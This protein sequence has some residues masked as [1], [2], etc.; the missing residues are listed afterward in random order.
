M[1]LFKNMLSAEESLFVNEIALDFDYLPKLLPHRDH[2]QFE[3]ATCIKP[4]FQK[5]SGKHILITGKP[6]IGK[7]AA[8]RF[9]LRD[10]HRETDKIMPIY[11]NCWKKD[12]AHKVVVE[13]CNQLNYKWVINKKTDELLTAISEILNKKAAVFVLDEVDKLESEQIIYQLLEDIYHKCLFLI[14][15]EKDWLAKLDTRVRSRL[16]PELMEFEPYNYQETCDIL[17]QRVEYAFVPGVWGEDA[18]EQ[19]VEKTAKLEDIRTGIFL[20]K[21][22]GTIAENRSSRKIE[23]QDAEKAISKLES[24]KIRDSKDL[25]DSEKEI[26]TLIKEHSG[27]NMTEIFEIYNKHDNVSYR[28]FQRRIK[29]LEESGLIRTEEGFGRGKSTNLYPVTPEK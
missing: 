27:N 10:M 13:I 12:T 6:G 11:I 7:T 22:T 24:F 28:T 21:E 9:V 23:L 15:N 16:I 20:L 2:H 29:N 17:K 18:F 1:N 5:R 19:I 4:L 25:T 3:M 8:T 14:T 26:L